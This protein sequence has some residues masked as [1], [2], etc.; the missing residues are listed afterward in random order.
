MQDSRG[1]SIPV[2]AQGKNP[3]A[4]DSDFMSRKEGVTEGGH[5]A[6]G[7]GTPL[8]TSG[9]EDKQRYAKDRQHPGRSHE[10]AF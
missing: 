5:P 4:R 1:R 3:G 2:S 9:T 8:K 6:D 10:A 7:M